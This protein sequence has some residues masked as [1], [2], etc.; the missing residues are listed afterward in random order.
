MSFIKRIFGDQAVTTP[1]PNLNPLSAKPTPEEAASAAEKRAQAAREAAAAIEVQVAAATD[2]QLQ[3]WA[4][5][6]KRGTLRMAAAQALSQRAST[7]NDKALWDTLAKTAADKDR[8]VYKLAREQVQRLAA[9]HHAADAARELTERF[10]ALAAKQPVDLTRL[11]EADHAL[12]AL[13]RDANTPESAALMAPVHAARAAVNAQLD[14]QQTAQRSMAT[15]ERKADQLKVQLV[16]GQH[17]A[18]ASEHAT[19]VERFNAINAPSVPPQ[20]AQR[21]QAALHGL[22]AVLQ[23]MLARTT[24]SARQANW[25]KPSRRS[26]VP[27]SRLVKPC[28]K[29]SPPP[30]CRMTWPGHWHAA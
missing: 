21:T 5:H 23:T 1:A 3:D 8:R 13:V 26:T 25:A 12:D 16:A 30:S 6:D 29:L 27:T 9:Q 24:P 28:K 22:E 14:T 4:L 19:L 7:H 20:L 18:D 11:I 17:A 10:T 15:L 2:A